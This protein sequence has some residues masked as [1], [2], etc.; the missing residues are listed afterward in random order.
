MIDEEQNTS[1]KT[2]ETMS[3]LASPGIEPKTFSDRILETLQKKFGSVN[4]S[5]NSVPRA[6]KIINQ[7]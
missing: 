1:R 6:S 3:T 7:V 5:V 4:L 2:T